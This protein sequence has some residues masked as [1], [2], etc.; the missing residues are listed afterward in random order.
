PAASAPR[1]GGQASDP[2]FIGHSCPIRLGL[3]NQAA[4]PVRCSAAYGE[5][6]VHT[7]PGGR[8]EEANRAD[9]ALAEL[10]PVVLPTVDPPHGSH[11]GPDFHPGARRRHLP[12]L[13]EPHPEGSLSHGAATA[14]RSHRGSRSVRDLPEL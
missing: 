12:D 8:N 1:S 6:A 11:A 3:D 13:L 2:L 9:T 7:E 10:G 4:S 14:S 5:R